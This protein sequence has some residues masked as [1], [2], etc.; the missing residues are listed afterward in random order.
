LYCHP[1]ATD[2]T[3]SDIACVKT[4]LIGTYVELA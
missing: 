1:W 2:T 3:V 4:L